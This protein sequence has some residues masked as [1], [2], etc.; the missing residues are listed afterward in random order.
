[1][2]Q[3]PIIVKAN[4]PVAAFHYALVDV[5]P[6]GGG[7]TKPPTVF[8]GEVKELKVE[9]PAPSLYMEAPPIGITALDPATGASQTVTH[10]VGEC[11]LLEPPC[12]RAIPRFWDPVPVGSTVAHQPSRSRWDWLWR[13]G[14]FVARIGDFVAGI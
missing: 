5:E 13:I 12:G 11:E 10:D 3:I 1:M 4:T 9:T 2:K 8:V 14:D 7:Y 6:E